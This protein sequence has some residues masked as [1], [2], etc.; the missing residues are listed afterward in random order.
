MTTATRW[1][2]VPLLT[3]ETAQSF[4]LLLL[5]VP[6]TLDEMAACSGDAGGARGGWSAGVRG[7]CVRVTVCVACAWVWW[8]GR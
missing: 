5:P 7:V 3:D 1:K 2:E 4:H 6:G 8:T